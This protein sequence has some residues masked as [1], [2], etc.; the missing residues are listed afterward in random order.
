MEKVKLWFRKF[1][2][3]WTACMLCMAQGDLSVMNVKHAITASKTGSIAGLA[4]VIASFFPWDIKWLGV[5]LTG[6]F[7]MM[8][9]II[10]HPTHFGGAWTEAITTGAVAACIAFVFEKFIIKKD[11]V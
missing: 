1:S 3:A 7:T 9:D 10:V 8:A 6:L 2:E 11:I 5:W 4:F